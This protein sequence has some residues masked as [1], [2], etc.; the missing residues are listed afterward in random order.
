[1]QEEPPKYKV[2]AILREHG[3]TWGEI[4]RT[5]WPDLPPEKGRAYAK[6][7]YK[8]FLEKERKQNKKDEIVIPGAS[9]PTL[10]AAWGGERDALAHRS[11]EDHTVSRRK[12]E[13]MSYREAMKADLEQ[14]C[15]GFLSF[16]VEDWDLRR[17]YMQYVR[18]VNSHLYLLYGK[19]APSSVKSP[20]ILA[21]VY[22]VLWLA[23]WWRAPH[24]VLAARKRILFVLGGDRKK[25]NKFLKHLQSFLVGAPEIV[26]LW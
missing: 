9:Y 17:E 24:V 10:L 5:L 20:K 15:Y 12:K 19:R 23:L 18:A 8:H 11:P 16:L 7:L 3:L 26:F 22:A 2:V 13:L 14:A 4:A 6:R 1:M 21:Y 25:L